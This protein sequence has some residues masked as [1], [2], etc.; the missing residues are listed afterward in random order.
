MIY[1]KTHY[2]CDLYSIEIAELGTKRIK[3]KYVY[4]ESSLRNV[5]D[6]LVHE[7]KSC[8]LALWK[9]P[10]YDGDK[11]YWYITLG[12]SSYIKNMHLICNRI[13]KKDDAKTCRYNYFE[14][15]E[16]AEHLLNQLIAI[17]A[18]Y[19]IEICVKY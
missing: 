16:D 4:G 1:L 10:M 2:A 6:T 12:R 15:K 13:A 11:D 3:E 18:K 17:F 9:E 8:M 14:K 5:F 7:V 19:G